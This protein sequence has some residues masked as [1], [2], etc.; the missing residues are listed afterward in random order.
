[1]QEKVSH[2]QYADDT[3]FLCSN[4]PDNFKVIKGILQLVELISG[5]KVNFEKCGIYGVMNVQQDDLREKTDLMGCFVMTLPIRYIGMKVGV[6][7]HKRETW[8]VLIQ[9]V[10]S[11]LARWNGARISLGGKV[12]LIKSVLSAMPVYCLSFFLLAKQTIHELTK[13]Q[14]CFL[15][16][17]DDENKK[18]HWVKWEEV[19]K[20]REDGG[21]GIRELSKFNWALVGKWVWRLLNQKGRLWNRILSSRYGELE[22]VMVRRSSRVGVFKGS[23]WWRDMCKLYWGQFDDGV[24]RE[25]KKKVGYGNNTLFWQDTW[26]GGGTIN[27]SFS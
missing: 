5:L 23:L 26:V 25:F 13:I 14:C 22:R 21:L 19:C 3:A 20:K 18:I 11:K 7:H 15:W 1:M 9:K 2:L 4:H 27:I 17:G 8:A 6:D 12:T 24:R 10:K 16:G